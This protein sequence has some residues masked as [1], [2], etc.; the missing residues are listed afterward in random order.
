[1][2]KYLE[3]NTWGYVKNNEVIVQARIWYYKD[4]PE[5][6]SLF[7]VGMIGEFKCSKNTTLDES[8]ILFDQLFEELKKLGAMKVVGPMDGNT[9]QSYRLTTYYGEHDPFPLEP[10][11]PSHFIDHFINAGF[12]ED[13][14]YSSYITNINEW[15]DK[16]IDKL[17]S[18]FESLSFREL[19]KEDLGSIFDLTLQSFT[20]NPYYLPISKIAYLNKYEGLL[21][22][23][24]PNISWVVYDGNEL[25]G[26]LFA[27]VD[28]QSMNKR[29][30]L[31]TIAVNEERKYA[32][33][34][35][36]LLSK[37]IDQSKSIGIEYAIHALM[38]DKNPVQNIIKDNSELLRKYTLYK[39]DLT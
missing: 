6:S 1:M 30:I 21:S 7:Q 8:K 34:G 12:I 39:R 36:Y 14:V 16:R 38:H 28:H 29:V 37:L 20:R 3:N 5:D 22:L 18:R 11:T 33:L 17:H 2:L 10:Y 24:K 9:W 32:G 4:L 23:L 15:Q 26:Y 27:M 19:Q 31:K 25:V 35:T 13:E